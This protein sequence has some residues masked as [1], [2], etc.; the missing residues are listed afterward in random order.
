MKCGSFHL[1]QFIQNRQFQSVHE[2]FK[3]LLIQTLIWVLFRFSS[4]KS[5]SEKILF[6]MKTN[7]MILTQSCTRPVHVPYYDLQLENQFLQV[8]ALL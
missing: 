1:V 4:R 7:E 2:A 5:I 6:L 8:Q 3:D